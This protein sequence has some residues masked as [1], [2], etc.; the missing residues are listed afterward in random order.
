LAV[1][2]WLEERAADQRKAAV[3]A[4]TDVV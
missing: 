4:S 2:L 1:S 3:E